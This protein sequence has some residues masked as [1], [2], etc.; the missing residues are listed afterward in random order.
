MLR[1]ALAKRQILVRSKFAFLLKE[2]TKI[3]RCQGA[4][5]LE[6]SN[7][8]IDSLIKELKRC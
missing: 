8:T 7:F 2:H 3:K 6:Q 1:E 4:E 5:I